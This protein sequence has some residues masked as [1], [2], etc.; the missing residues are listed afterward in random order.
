MTP[1]P[2]SPAAESTVNRRGIIYGHVVVLC[3]SAS[4]AGATIVQGRYAVA[5]VNVA[6]VFGNVL[7]L[8][9]AYSRALTPE[10]RA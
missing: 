10:P 7:M 8:L 6:V 9:S 3:I 2:G 1:T 5:A 4:S